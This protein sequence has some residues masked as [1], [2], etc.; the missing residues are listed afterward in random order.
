MIQYIQYSE[1]SFTVLYS[2]NAQNPGSS[3][4]EPVMQNQRWINHKGGTPQKTNVDTQK[5]LEKDGKG[6]SF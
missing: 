3:D 6:G 4:D 1:Y 5:G 2:G